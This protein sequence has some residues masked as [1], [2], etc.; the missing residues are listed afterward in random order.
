[1]ADRFSPGVRVLT[2]RTDPSH[3]TRVPRYARGVIG[4]IVEALG[5]YPLPDDRARGLPANPMPAYTVLFAA[6]DL[7]DEGDHGVTVDIWQCH[8]TPIEETEGSTTGRPDR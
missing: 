7:F 8:L 4:T 2:S 3:H 1:M 6:R 5:S